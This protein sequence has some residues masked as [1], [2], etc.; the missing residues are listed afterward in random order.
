MVTQVNPAEVKHHSFMHR[1]IHTE[2]MIDAPP[3][4]VWSILTDAENM[5]SWSSSFKGF[6]GELYNDAPIVLKVNAMGRNMEVKHT[7]H[8]F[9]DGK[10]LGWSDSPGPGIRD[11]HKYMVQEVEAG[12]TR[13]IQTDEFKGWGVPVWG[14][15]LIKQVA[16]VYPQ[17]NQDLKEEAERRSS[18]E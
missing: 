8:H 10:L 11:N 17:F 15:I 2:V 9:E 16:S 12:K 5:A 6:F 13:F 4:L 7:L 1:A 14:W 3:E 18:R